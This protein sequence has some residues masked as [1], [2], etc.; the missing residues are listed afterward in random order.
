MNLTETALS[1]FR[2][3]IFKTRMTDLRKA[4]LVEI[5][6]DRE[7]EFVDQDL[8]KEAVKQFV[9]MG[10]KKNIEIKRYPRTDSATLYWSGE[11]DLTLYDRE[12]EK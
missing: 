3:E 4:I 10:Y 1:F 12:F 8:I 7:N 5:R 9:F 2:E 6:K 11:R